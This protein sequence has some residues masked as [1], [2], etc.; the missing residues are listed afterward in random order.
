VRVRVVALSCLLVLACK[1]DEA[2]KD[3]D[4]RSPAASAEPE[5]DGDG[6]RPG[7]GL[8]TTF[9]DALAGKRSVQSLEVLPKGA[10]VLVGANLRELVAQPT[11]GR[12][13]SSLGGRQR[14]QLDAATECGVG[15]DKW[16]HFVIGFA[17][18]G[19]DMAMVVE[20]EGIGTRP[21]LD[22]L[23]KEIGNFE[24]SPDGKRLS[25]ATGGGV[26]LSDDAIAFASPAWMPLLEQRIE[27]QGVSA[28]DDIGPNLAR[29]DQSKTL[30]LAG[31]PFGDLDAAS[32][33][34]GTEIQGYS[35]WIDLTA[36]MKMKLSLAV[37]D[38]AKTRGELDSKWQGLKSM[39]ASVAPSSVIDSVKITADGE[40]VHIQLSASQADLDKIAADVGKSFF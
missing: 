15:K 25:D 10:V 31:K 8:A 34:L 4:A 33:A 30:W 9:Q 5:P 6:T 35:G 16:R 12:L 13:E 20:A 39:A 40:L 27:G 29:A 32:D 1:D 38:A 36:G 17:P 14:G 21:V 24:L 19:D 11:W 3:S 7:R 2:P 37:P 26:V 22:C 23:A 28:A 18:K